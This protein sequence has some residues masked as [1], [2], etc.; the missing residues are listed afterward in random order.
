[1]RANSWLNHYE[2]RTEIFSTKSAHSKQPN[3]K[4]IKK[5]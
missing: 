2:L 5:F 4:K 3:P 1:I